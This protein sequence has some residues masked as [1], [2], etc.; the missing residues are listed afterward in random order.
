[1][2]SIA[3]KAPSRIPYLAAVD[4]PETVAKRLAALPDL[5]VFKLM[6]HAHDSFDAWLRFGGSLLSDL[7]LDDQLRELAILRV[8]HLTPGADYEWVQHEAIAREIGVEP[9]R[10][11]AARYE[12]P[13]EADDALVLS[14]T[15]QVVL[16]AMPNDET[17]AACAARFSSR[18]IVEL[19]LVIGQYMMLGRLMATA[20]IDIDLPTHLDQLVRERKGRHG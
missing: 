1:M 5:N 10:I 17:F 6:A 7:T 3:G 20:R 12:V 19:I 4:A 15:E 16:S 8:A 2:D 11:A 9:T 18:E 13:A 14:F